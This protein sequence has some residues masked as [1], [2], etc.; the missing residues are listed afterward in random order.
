MSSWCR[1]SAAATRKASPS[2]GATTTRN[3]TLPMAEPNALRNASAPA[4]LTATPPP[5][6]VAPASA[7]PS[8][9]SSAPAAAKRK[10]LFGIL[11]LVIVAVAAIV[12]LWLFL[13]ASDMRTDDA[14]VDADLVQVTPLFGGPVA[15]TYVSNTDLVKKGQL[16]VLLD[17]ADAKIA[18][19]Q[20]RAD[21]G[22]VQRKVRGYFATDV[23]L[24][25]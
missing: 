4:P 14:Y 24:G 23:A 19:A 6:G 9:V 16:L 12:A 5:A 7:A 2:A 11:A 25:G 10:R 17:D 1:R 15:A 18:L 20:A 21:L 3:R 13:T 8:G 22:Q